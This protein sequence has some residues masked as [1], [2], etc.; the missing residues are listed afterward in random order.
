MVPVVATGQ[1]RKS[2][3]R[4]ARP[5]HPS[6]MNSF[7]TWRYPLAVAAWFLGAGTVGRAA[8]DAD[9]AYTIIVS[10][11]TLARPEW[12]QVVA[13]LGEKHRAQTVTFATQVAECLPELRTQFPRYACFVARP[14]EATREFVAEVHRLTRRLD[15]DPYADVF[16]GILTGY[17]AANALRIAR[18]REP[19]IIH[20][21]AAGTDLELSNCEAGVWFC[22]LNAG[23]SVRKEKGGS[24]QRTTNG[25]ADSTESI[26]KLLNDYRPDLFVT[27][28]HATERDWQIG[29]RYRNGFFKCA[30]GE[31]YGLDT[32]GRKFPV[33][34]PN[35]KVYM[36]V[37]NCLMGHIDQPDCMALAWLNGAGVMQMFGYTVPTWFG[38]AGWGGL[39]YFVEQPGRYTFTEAFFANQLALEHRLTS[40]FPD[41]LD[42][43]SDENG[44]PSQAITLTDAA[45]AAKLTANDGRGLL[46][47][48]DVVAFYGDPA[49]SARMAPQDC[50][51]DQ[52]LTVKDGTYTLELKPRR[53]AETFKPV[54]LNGSQRGGRP[55]IAFLPTRVKAVRLRAGAEFKPVITD[56][57]V[58]L[59]N[60]GEC[61]PALAYRVVFTAQLAR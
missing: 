24:P 61:D 7:L 22:E 48:R 8:V 11:A 42:A 36:P 55:I 44:R 45:R 23:H 60:P 46:F 20:K 21:A 37:G 58:L 13:A 35:P 56:N 29:F 27:S 19:L 59:P 5:S 16:W 33:H 18:H 3:E 39:D 38:Y 32:Q 6:P 50:A 53:G 31:L 41:L 9:A 25:P 4:A 28:G 52:Q 40:A 12:K 34:S 49:W 43:T 10:Q 51:W 30:H 15:D 1:C 17:D 26:V 14:E 57:F 2:F 54:N 47:D